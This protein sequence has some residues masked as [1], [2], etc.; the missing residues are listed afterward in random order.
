[1]G[2][3]LSIKTANFKIKGLMKRKLNVCESKERELWEFG[4]M[5]L[6][7]FTPFHSF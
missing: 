7:I 6:D 5:K 3:F 4:A 2:C 1:M